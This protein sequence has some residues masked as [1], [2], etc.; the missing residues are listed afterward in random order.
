MKPL[1]PGCL[2]VF[3]PPKAPVNPAEVG[4]VVTCVRYV[5]K[6]HRVQGDNMWETDKAF[7]W[8]FFFGLGTEKI[9]ICPAECL[10]RIDGYDA[11]KDEKEDRR[12]PVLVYVEESDFIGKS[13]T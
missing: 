11:S 9:N 1:E 13:R 12:R 2:A 8:S 3:M 10:M 4:M 5:G 6:D 7:T